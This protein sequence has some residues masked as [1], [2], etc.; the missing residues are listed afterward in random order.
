MF[1]WTQILVW[2]RC[3]IHLIFISRTWDKLKYYILQPIS[4]I[5]YDNWCLKVLRKFMHNIEALFFGLQKRVSLV[6]LPLN[7]SGIHTF[8][9]VS[10]KDIYTF[11]SIHDH[12]SPF[13]NHLR[14]KHTFFPYQ[15]QNNKD[16][17]LKE[18]TSRDGWSINTSRMQPWIARSVSTSTAIT[19]PTHVY[20]HNSCISRFTSS[21]VFDISSSS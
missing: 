6:N 17:I 10:N 20:F 8:K 7:I 1:A 13:T 3:W 15:K 5:L 18:F 9:W 21:M 19:F 12:R 4:L 2:S 14:D 11:K 16:I